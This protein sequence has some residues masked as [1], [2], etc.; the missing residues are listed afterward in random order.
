MGANPELMRAG[1]IRE[2]GEERAE[3]GTGDGSRTLEQPIPPP[4]RTCPWQFYRTGI[5][6][7][8]CGIGWRCE[9]RARIEIG[10]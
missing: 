8:L 4:P 10:I 1:S 2:V 3:G 7:F 5:Q 9:I 6:T